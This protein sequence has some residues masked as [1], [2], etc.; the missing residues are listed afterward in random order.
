[1]P[2]VHHRKPSLKSYPLW[3]G[4]RVFLKPLLSV[5]PLNGPG[6]AGLF[7]IDKFFAAG[8][9][10][11][12]V[13]REQV[14]LGG[15]R[16]ELSIPSGPSR[17][18]ADTAILYLHGGAF[19]VGGVGTH[20]SIAAR[21]SRHCE[22][23]VFSLVYRQLPAAGVG[24]SVA[25]AVAAY[26]ELV[27]ERGFRRVVVAGDSAG[28]FLASKVVEGAALAGLPAPIA[29]IGF[30]PLL[31]LDLG[32]NPDRS[33]RSDAYLP[34]HQLV[35]LSR[36]FARGPIAY[37]GVRRIADLDPTSFPPTIMFT[38]ENELLEP[39]VIELVENLMEA[40]VEAVAHSYSWQVHAFPV[41]DFHHRETMDAIE[42]AAAFTGHAIREAK[43][44]DER[45]SKWAG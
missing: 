33:S 24:T 42:A 22:T 16:A 8:R 29:L 20:R 4:S 28:G 21:L 14:E 7:V 36:H 40:G 5:W 39:D 10:P 25:D 44:A 17:R 2:I 3:I 12:S 26:R 11:R 19:V 9:K 38:A 37:V 1:M 45:K 23:P 31:D 35:N 30:S 27:T 34:K 41:F 18:D 13:V 32:D 15:C 6:M 43:D